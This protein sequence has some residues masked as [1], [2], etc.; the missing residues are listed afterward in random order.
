MVPEYRIG[1]QMEGRSRA[2]FVFYRNNFLEWPKEIWKCNLL[3]GIRLANLSQTV[4]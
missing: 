3:A 2:I 4:L 1:K